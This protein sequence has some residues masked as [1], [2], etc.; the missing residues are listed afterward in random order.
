MAQTAAE[1]K[2][3]QRQEMLEKGFV[4]KD[5]WLSKESLYLIEKYKIENNLKS[6]DDALNQLLKALN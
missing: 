1:R 3:K 6:N 4:R 5:L 2:A